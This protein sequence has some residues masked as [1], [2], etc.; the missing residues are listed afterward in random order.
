MSCLWLYFGPDVVNRSRSGLYTRKWNYQ[1]RDFRFS[2]PYYLQT[3]KRKFISF[4]EKFTWK[5]RRVEYNLIE[6]WLTNLRGR[7]ETSVLPDRR[8][9]VLQKRRFA[10]ESSTSTPRPSGCMP[11]TEGPVK[12]KSLRV[13]HC[14]HLP[15]PRGLM[16]GRWEGGK[17]TS[18]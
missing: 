9:G 16:I 1:A 8:D 2:V 11:L 3:L 6:S 17:G 13:I 15:C 18:V 14:G 12:G 4:T 7:S 5:R 10:P